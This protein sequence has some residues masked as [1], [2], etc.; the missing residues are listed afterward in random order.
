MNSVQLIFVYDH[1][2]PDYTA[3]GPITA[4]ANLAEL[5]KEKTSIK[6]ITSAYEYST[7]ETLKGIEWD[8]WTSWKG[9]PVWYATDNKSLRA[10]FKGLD[11]NNSIIYLNG[12]LSV[13]YFLFPLW[14]TYRLN[15]KTVISPRGMLQKGAINDSIKKIFYLKML[16]AF[17]LFKHAGWHATDSQESEDIRT[18]FDADAVV[19]PDVPVVK[20]EEK[21]SF[22]KHSGQ[23]RLVYFSL[24][25][26][27]KNLLFFLELLLDPMLAHVELDIIGPVKDSHYWNLCLQRIR[28]LSNPERI[29]YK[30]EI[31]PDKI[32]VTLPFYHCLV[33]PTHG[34][35]FGHA[36]IEMLASSRPVLISDKTPWHDLEA[37][38]AGFS[39]NLQ[40]EKWKATLI[41]ISNWNQRVFDE[42][43]ASSFNYYRSKFNFDDLKMRYLKLFSS[44]T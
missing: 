18:W 31:N 11:K 6:I 32:S 23:L 7:K 25:A 26:E 28:T 4:L 37:F 39:L 8:Q 41:T 42:V 34:E 9:I 40:K 14:L 29:Q 44:N 3:G 5:L 36:I 17:G 38:G 20:R 1:Y 22:V 16:A 15:L 30:G 27:K 2:Y 24:I 35:N 21:I 12:V 43:S 19:I 13:R 33:L 10:A